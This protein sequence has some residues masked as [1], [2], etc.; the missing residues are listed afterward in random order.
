MMLTFFFFFSLSLQG[1][2]QDQ[3]LQ[4]DQQKLSQFFDESSD[5]VAAKALMRDSATPTRS[6]PA[7]RHAIAP[8]AVSSVSV[9]SSL[10]ESSSVA[11]SHPPPPR[12]PPGNY[13]ADDSE[14]CDDAAETM[15]PLQSMDNRRASSSS[16]SAS[17]SSVSGA[18][19]SHNSNNKNNRGSSSSASMSTASVSGS[20]SRGSRE[21]NRPISSAL[22]DVSN[23]TTQGSLS[24]VPHFSA[25]ATPTAR[26]SKSVTGASSVSQSSEN[27]S[28]GGL[29]FTLS[30]LED[31]PGGSSNSSNSNDFRAP[32]PLSGRG[33]TGQRLPQM[34]SML[35]TM[36]RNKRKGLTSQS[37]S[38]R[39]L[40]AGEAFL[41]GE[42][43]RQAISTAES[44]VAELEHS[45]VAY[46]RTED[47]RLRLRLQLLQ[48]D[49]ESRRV[50]LRQVAKHQRRSHNHGGGSLTVG[51]LQPTATATKL[52]LSGVHRV[53]QLEESL[54]RDWLARAGNKQFFP[55]ST[56]RNALGAKGAL[57]ESG[58]LR[59]ALLYALSYLSEDDVM[60][61]KVC[62]R[63][64]YNVCSEYFRFRPVTDIMVELVNTEEV[65]L[66]SLDSFLEYRDL[67]VG[68]QLLG[69][70]DSAAIFQPVE[71]IQRR[72][73]H[74]L[75]LLRHALSLD[76]PNACQFPAVFLAES[77]ELLKEYSEYCAAYPGAKAMCERLLARKEVSEA[78]GPEISMMTLDSFLIRPVQRIPRYQLFFE[79][80]VRKTRRSA[81]HEEF[82]AA[83]NLLQRITED[84]NHGMQAAEERRAVAE[85]LAPIRDAPIISVNEHPSLLCDHVV[86]LNGAIQGRMVTLSDRII[87]ATLYATT[88]RLM[89]RTQYY[90]E[91]I[92]VR[93]FD[94]ARSFSVQLCSADLETLLISFSA[95]EDRRI[96]TE[97]LQ[98]AQAKRLTTTT[99]ATA[100]TSTATHPPPKAMQLV[101][102][103]EVEGVVLVRPIR[104]KFEYLSHKHVF[105][106]ETLQ[107]L[108][109]WHGS[110]SSSREK[111]LAARYVEDLLYRE[112]HLDVVRSTTG[113]EFFDLLGGCMADVSSEPCNTTQT[114]QMTLFLSDGKEGIPQSRVSHNLLPYAGNGCAVIDARGGHIFVWASPQS[115]GSTRDKAVRYAKELGEVQGR[116]VEFVLGGREPPLLQM[117]FLDWPGMQAKSSSA[118]SMATA[119]S[120]SAAPS[121][122]SVILSPRRAFAALGSS[123]G[124]ST[125]FSTLR[126][127]KMRRSPRSK[128]HKK[129]GGVFAGGGGFE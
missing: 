69:A 19:S 124:S 57:G 107:R 10:S 90:L 12:L 83:C 87:V 82:V 33:R 64:W 95:S 35:A 8:S 93:H 11:A 72:S 18:S 112:P 123:G 101:R 30:S 47:E 89:F 7:I 24:S 121:D 1:L 126:L 59:I 52:Q 27:S 22:Q 106:L 40:G 20:V 21:V 98:A 32:T 100:A 125:S 84:I 127:S 111:A 115:T 74:V 55:N 68:R 50:L 34:Q 70:A 4:H 53:K 16:S 128:A 80:L 58:P 56:A 63:A 15:G 39:I 46:I 88:Q 2:P 38:T 92:L 73:K 65:Y 109:V 94:D 14:S 41:D 48:A 102:F 117:L 116:S 28:S 75:H 61:V 129:K 85:A 118:A 66:H 49:V 3:T 44:E 25:M 51:G 13:I 108:Y 67:L 77:P 26:P 60:N 37:S 79:T 54:M 36:Q 43:L 81:Q 113:A 17:V 71:R 29:T 114:P 99:A 86:V 105:L 120:M 31:E 5:S 6:T 104:A 9:S 62:C 78:L 42:E 91:E 103:S 122:G 76:R 97:K 110:D 96:W 45:L 119:S 23:G